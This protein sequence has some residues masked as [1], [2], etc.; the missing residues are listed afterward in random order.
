MCSDSDSFSSSSDSSSEI[1]SDWTQNQGDS[2][3]NDTEEPAHQSLR[4]ET[5]LVTVSC[6]RKY[7]RS[8]ADRRKQRKM[9]SEDCTIADFL[10]KFRRTF[11]ANSTEVVEK[12]L[13]ADEPHKRFRK[14]LDKRV[15]HKHIALKASGN[16]AHQKI[17]NASHR[18]HGLRISFSFKQNRFVGNVAYLL[19]PGKK[20]STDI[21]PKPATFPAN[22]NIKK[23]MEAHRQ[24]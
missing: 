13:C 11:S 19:D 3:D 8:L 23:V 6:P 10:K 17:A 14:S 1:G 4:G 2:T 12:A 18:E 20:P 24:V 7:L 15:R 16:F 22:M 9:I 5:A 21:D